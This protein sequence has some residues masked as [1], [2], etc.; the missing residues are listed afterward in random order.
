M[1]G[2]AEILTNAD[3]E[4]LAADL[5]TPLPAVSDWT[6]T[7]IAATLTQSADYQPADAPIFDA[8]P[9][10]LFLVVETGDHH[11][12]IVDGD[13]F[14]VLKRLPTPFAVH[15]GPKFTPDG[16]YT[17]I[18]SRDGSVQKI[19]LWS[20]GEVG[21]VRAAINSRNIAISADGKWLAVANYLPRT[22]TILSSEDLSLARVFQVVDLH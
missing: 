10:N 18:M 5:E 20:L 3:I 2:Y 9:L 22:L 16:R 14:E 6:P 4:N 12:S 7:E 8:D 11:V 17:F 13:T 19:D 15:G 21:R 1:P